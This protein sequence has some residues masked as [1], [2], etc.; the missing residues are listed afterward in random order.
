MGNV[1]KMGGSWAVHG[2]CAHQKEKRKTW[3]LKKRWGNAYFFKALFWRPS[4][5]YPYFST[6]QRL[7]QVEKTQ[8]AQ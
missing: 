2:E 6:F 8:H 5:V 3:A 1:K 7:G 4:L